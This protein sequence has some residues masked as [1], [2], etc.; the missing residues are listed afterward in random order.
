M[1]AQSHRSTKRLSL[2]RGLA[3]ALLALGLAPAALA[4]PAGNEMCG[5]GTTF[6]VQLPG[7][8]SGI[9]N[10]DGLF[11]NIIVPDPLPADSVTL[12]NGCRF[13]VLL[14]S[15]YRQ[16]AALDK[17]IFYRVAEF[18]ASNNGYVHMAWWNN[19]L[20]EYMGGP[21][22]AANVIVER[23]FPF[24]DYFIPPTPG[25]LEYRQRFYSGSFFRTVLSR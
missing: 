11:R 1:N 14:I 21:L 8:S 3:W 17:I 9:D 12:P 19:L 20:K 22:H 6:T 10:F 5:D 4:Q 24:D 7:K 15:G 18:A 25:G 23:F 13:Y 16:N 2:L